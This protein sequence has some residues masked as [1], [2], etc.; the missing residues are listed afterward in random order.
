MELKNKVV[1]ITGGTHGIGAACARKWNEMGCKVAI[2]ARHEQAELLDELRKVGGEVLF[3]PADLKREQECRAAAE[4]IGATWGRIDVLIHSAGGGV[5][6]SLLSLTSSQWFEAFDIH[7]H[8]AFHLC[9]AAVPFMKRHGG[10][11]IVFVSSAAGMRGVKNALA[12]AV[13]KGAL[14]Q[15]ARA[16]AAELADDGIRVNA[17]S[18]GVIRTRFQDGLTAEQVRHNVDNRIPLHREGTPEDVADLIVHVATNSYI[19][20]ENIVI[21]GGL[22]MRIA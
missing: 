1:V 20:G 22:T 10:G 9:Q 15:L 4:R 6:G 16:L 18:P 11:A 2:V 3:V 5:P 14:P 13:V 12:Y 17:V 21:D 19:T 7:V 8:A